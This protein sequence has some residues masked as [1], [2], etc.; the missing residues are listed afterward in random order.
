MNSQTKSILRGFWATILYCFAIQ[1]IGIWTSLP[2]IMSSS[3]DF[4]LNYFPLIQSSL[5]FLAIVLFVYFEQKAT[6]KK[7]F[8]PSDFKWYLFAGLIGISFVFIQTPLNLGYNFLFGTDF[9][10]QYNFTLQPE[11]WNN[12]LLGY[13]LLIPISEELFFRSYIQR[14]LEKNG[15]PL[16]AIFWTAI[17]FALIHA[18]EPIFALDFSAHGWHL[19]FIALIGG[20]ISG[21][22]YYK[23]KSMGPPIL[24]HVLWNFGVQAFS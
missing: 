2:L 19:A 9:Q 23:T 20:F 11:T 7:L 16:Q 8:P 12:G 6:L 3:Q 1:C 5:Q 4:V 15:N 10:I 13:I 18:M 22:I 21:G 24:F 14:S 17:F